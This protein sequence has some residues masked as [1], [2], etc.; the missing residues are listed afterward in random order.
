L[1]RRI[2]YASKHINHAYLQ[3]GGAVASGFVYGS[4]VGGQFFDES[5]LEFGIESLWKEENN[6]VRRERV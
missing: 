2:R 3:P 4:S 6:K 1:Y 5:F